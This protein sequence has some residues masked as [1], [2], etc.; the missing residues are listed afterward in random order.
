[1]AKK[2]KPTRE[3]IF[4]DAGKRMRTEFEEVRRNVPHP[5]VAGGEGEGIVR[6]FLSSHLPGRFRVTDGFIIDREDH[7]SSH[8]D[9]I[10]YDV[11]NCP[12]YRT[13]QHGMIIPND[14]VAA[15]FE[16]KFKLTT[17][18]EETIDKIHEAKNLVKTR[19]RP[20]RVDRP[21]QLET[22]GVVFAFECGLEYQVVIDRW[23]SRL[24]Q[25]NPLHKSC[26]MVV[27]LDRGIW[28]TVTQVPGFGVAP[29]FID[30][31]S[32]A[33]PV[34]TRVGIAYFEYGDRT[35]DAMMRLLLSH[36]T[37][38]RHRVDHPGFNFS[39]LG[40][41]PIKWMGTYVAQ[42]KMQYSTVG[43]VVLPPVSE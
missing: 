3:T 25:Q 20:D 41:R 31:V 28:V 12:V 37:F 35:L 26:Y 33:A 40:P 1:M 30:A 10:V 5:G 23:H 42:G 14:N 34:G 29:A 43:G 27:V 24:T 16:V 2:Q 36:L 15:L 9:A 21:E 8:E 32:Q 22:C 39:A 18:V 13:S 17:L 11:L 6:E 4:Q 38:F 19:T 7:V